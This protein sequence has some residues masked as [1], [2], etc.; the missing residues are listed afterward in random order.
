[1]LRPFGLLAAWTATLYV[2]SP[3]LA[4]NATGHRIIAAIAYER[5]TPRTRARVDELIRQHPD[6]AT[7][8]TRNA[9]ADPTQR[10]KP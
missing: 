2:A 5:L 10:D 4:W 6:Y 9:P 1:M 8:L 7:I 3:A